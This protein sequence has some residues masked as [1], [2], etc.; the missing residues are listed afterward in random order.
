V[1]GEKIVLSDPESYFY[2]TQSNVT[3]T[4]G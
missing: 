1:A 4:Q 3:I 2:T